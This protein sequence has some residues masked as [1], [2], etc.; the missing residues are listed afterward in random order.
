MQE[1]LW[2]IFN[3]FLEEVHNNYTIPW[4]SDF[5]FKCLYKM[6][7]IWNTRVYKIFLF[8][9]CEVN[10]RTVKKPFVDWS[11]QDNLLVGQVNI[12]KVVMCFFSFYHKFTHI[13][14]WTGIIWSRKKEP[15]TDWHVCCKTM[16]CMSSGS[17]HL[18]YIVFGVSFYVCIS[19]FKRNL[20]WNF[21]VFSA[22][23]WSISSSGQTLSHDICV[24]HIVTFTL[25]I[26]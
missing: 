10:Y 11:W 5:I 26:H 8:S 7:F 12:L 22:P 2:V 16:N 24:V 19:V 1:Q 23:S 18:V 21:C 9:C 4:K 15:V 14:K 6:Y 17:K 13:L 25:A 20:A 3:S